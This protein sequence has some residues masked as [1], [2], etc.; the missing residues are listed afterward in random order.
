MNTFNTGILSC[1]QDEL[2]VAQ[3]A[4]LYKSNEPSDRAELCVLRLGRQD[5]WELKQ[6]VPI[7]FDDDDLLEAGIKGDEMVRQWQTVTDVPA[8]DRFLCWVDYRCGFL[9][10]DMAADEASPK[11]RYVAL[12]VRPHNMGSYIPCM[13]YSRNLVSAGGGGAGAVRIV[14]VEPRCCCYGS[15]WSTCECC[16][17]FTVT[18]WTLSRLSMEE[19]ME[20]VKD[21]VLDCEELWA[22]PSYKGLPRVKLELPTVSA[23]DPDVICLMVRDPN[24]AAGTT[25]WMVEVA[26]N[27]KAIMSVVPYKDRERPEHHV[28]AKLRF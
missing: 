16:F 24:F 19:P 17:L 23:N 4:L 5:E 28:A 10:C 7:V 25:V 13:R 26:T 1:Y 22:L 8:A 3:L 12:P 20:W 6:A 9:L 14:N 18:T 27:S 2:L 11:L 15:R 21:G